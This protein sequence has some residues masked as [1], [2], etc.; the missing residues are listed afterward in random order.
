M[1]RAIISRIK[2]GHRTMPYPAAPLQVPERFRGYPIVPRLSRTAEHRD[3]TPE[4]PYGAFTATGGG[5]LDMGKC[6]FCAECP[7][8]NIQFSTDYQ[9]AVTN[10]DHLLVRP[11]LEH[12]YARPLPPDLR[13]LFGRSLKF[14]EVS[15]G[16]CNACEADVN[17]LS[18]IGWDLGR[19]GIQFVASP[20]HADGLWV[21]G[22]VTKNMEQALLTTY[23]SIPSPKIVVACGACA[24]NG[25]PYIDS[26]Q[27]C[28]G[29]DSL[30]PVDLYIPGCPPHPATILDGLLRILDKL[31]HL[32]TKL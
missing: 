29:V 5:C 18:T 13:R 14:R 21:T 9:L 24:I 23:E 15:A 16:G 27:A 31:P 12:H 19:F 25:G 30:I 28:N 32:S 2:Q 20:R 4:C 6:L 26:P 17:V 10:R 1:I 7:Q 22:P 8:G 3:E 11:G